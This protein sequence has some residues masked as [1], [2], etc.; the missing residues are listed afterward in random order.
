MQN[1]L[2][3]GIGGFVGA[4][5]R[6]AISSGAAKAFGSQLPYGTLVVNVAGAILIGLVLELS[7]S[8]GLV[9]ANLR[10]FLVT[11]I[12][13]GF[14]TFSAFSYETVALLSDGR[15]LLGG[16]NICLNVFLSLLGVVLGKN[17][18]GII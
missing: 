15:Y 16:L 18:A 4:C 3:I 2:I 11:G 1:L 17:I 13:G 10:L 14:T 12:L 7:S 5:I 6:Y 8:T 9:S